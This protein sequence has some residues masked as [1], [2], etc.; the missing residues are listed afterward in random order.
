MKPV[1]TS[2]ATIVLGM[3]LA[4]PFV[5]IAFV[6]LASQSDPDLA[7]DLVKVWTITVV[8]TC[9]VGWVLAKKLVR[10]AWQE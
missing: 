3:L 5:L 10:W 8:G 7:N 1:T 4:Q 6:V 9:A 2:L